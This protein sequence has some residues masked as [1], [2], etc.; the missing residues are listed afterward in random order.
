VGVP[1]VTAWSA[2]VVAGEIRSG[3]TVLI[4]GA[5]GAV[6]RTATQIAHWKN[7]RVIRVGRSEDSQSGTDPFINTKTMDLPAMVAA[8]TE[9][10]ASASC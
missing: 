3:D 7:T 10:I 4:T 8:L 5:S 1:F 2:L 6:G 9:D